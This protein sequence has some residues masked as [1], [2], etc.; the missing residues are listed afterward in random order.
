[1]LLV[2]FLYYDIHYLITAPNA[3]P[4][5]LRQVA[6]AATSVTLNWQ[7]PP[8][9]ARNGLIRL[10]YVFVTELETG[11]SFELNTTKTNYLVENLHP[12]YTY[13]FSVAAVTVATGI[14]SDSITLQT[15][16]AGEY[17]GFYHVTSLEAI[18]MLDFFLLSF[19]PNSSSQWFT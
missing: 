8:E 9:E 14:I 12:Y 17:K 3:S 13:N 7:P 6:I 15:S 10:Y 16:E 4:Q 2:T 1:M 11:R 18:S 19:V 5:N